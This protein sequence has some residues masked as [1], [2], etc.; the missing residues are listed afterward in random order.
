MCC[1]ADTPQVHFTFGARGEGLDAV[2]GGSGLEFSLASIKG[3]MRA[4]L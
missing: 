3:F 1:A 2:D 4:L